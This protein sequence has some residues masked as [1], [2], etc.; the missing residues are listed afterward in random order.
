MGRK[1]LPTSLSLIVTQVYVTLTHC[2][3]IAIVLPAKEVASCGTNGIA[4]AQVC[5]KQFVIP[6]SS[7]KEHSAQ[8]FHDFHH[9][10]SFPCMQNST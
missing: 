7:D 5:Q 2:Q 3:T 4:G 9:F 6:I 10:I 1:P 8:P